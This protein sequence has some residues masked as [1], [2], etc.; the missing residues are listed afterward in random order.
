MFERLDRRHIEDNLLVKVNEE[1]KG[2]TEI[3][4]E[5]NLTAEDAKDFIMGLFN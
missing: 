4:P 2:Y 3:K 1:P 5:T